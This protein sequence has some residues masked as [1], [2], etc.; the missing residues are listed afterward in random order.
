MFSDF[1]LISLVHAQMRGRFL[2]IGVLC[3]NKYIFRIV[4]HY[5]LFY[6]G[7]FTIMMVVVFSLY[8]LALFWKKP[9]ELFRRLLRGH[10]FDKI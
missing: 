9:P 5:I 8:G 4:R 1:E 2:R 7:R 3:C 6:L 10:F